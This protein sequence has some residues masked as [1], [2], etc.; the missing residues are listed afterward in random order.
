LKAPGPDANINTDDAMDLIP[1]L[2]HDATLT[3]D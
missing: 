2:F 1:P 3:Y